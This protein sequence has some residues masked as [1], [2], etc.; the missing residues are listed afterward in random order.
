MA[1]IAVIWAI[2]GRDKQVDSELADAILKGVEDTADAKASTSACSANEPQPKKRGLRD[3]IGCA[4]LWEAGFGA[5]FYNAYTVT[6]GSF[7]ATAL[8]LV[9]GVDPVLAGIEAALFS[10]VTMVGSV[11]MPAFAVKFK[12][13]KAL[14]ITL[15]IV[16]MGV[17]LWGF[18]GG[19]D[20]LR[21]VLF[22]L[23]GLLFGGLMPMFMSY[24]SILPQVNNENSGA[25][26]GFVTT[27]SMIGSSLMPSFIIT[28][29]AGG[30]YAMIIVIAAIIGALMTVPFALLPSLYRKN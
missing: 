15:P 1:V 16:S 5:A 14:C 28:P 26:G 13:A 18:F 6:S 7:L 22:P 10:A 23:G 20:I 9:N 3:V 29:L 17:L 30:D 27:L 2:F 4:G 12:H 8:V 19:S 25:A 21:C 11:A 24:P